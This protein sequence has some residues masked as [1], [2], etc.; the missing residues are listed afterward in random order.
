MIT[1]KPIGL[2][3]KELISRYYPL[4]GNGDCN[5]SFMSLYTRQIQKESFY[6]LVNGQLVIR[7]KFGNGQSTYTMPVGSGDQKKTILLLKE[8]AEREGNSL[9]IHGTFSSLSQWFENEFPGQFVI[10]THRDYSDYI[11]LR[12][13]LVQL[14]GKHFQPKRNHISRFKKKYD[15]QYRPLT[16]EQVPYCLNLLEKWDKEHG[17]KENENL[18]YEHE[19]IQIALRNFDQLELFGGAIWVNNQM[20]GFSYGAPVRSDVFAI[21]IEKADK[22]FDGSYSILNQEFARHI[23]EQY[24]YL[25]REEDLG[26]PGLRKSKLSYQPAFLLQKGYIQ[27]G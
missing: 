19:A 3:D 22:Q 12:D 11:Y 27:F 26:F 21:H 25:N 5:F 8:Q 4:Y 9:Y 10:Y 24:T 17:D 6:A 15:Y 2:E 1:F 20:V 18:Q 14:Q 7:C 16:V 13:D 23:P